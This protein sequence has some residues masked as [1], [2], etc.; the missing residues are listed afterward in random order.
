M[1]IEKTSDVILRYLKSEHDDLSMLAEDAVFTVMGSGQ[2]SRGPA[3]VQG[4]THY[5]YHIAFNAVFENR[6]LLFAE[7]NAVL[8]GYFVGKHIG[9]F[10]GIPATG[11]DVRVP[12]CIVYDVADN[13]I[14]QAR[15]YFE[16][17]VL[18]QQL[19]VSGG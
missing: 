2:E 18:M 16:L 19:G 15:I 12:I 8:E 3:A 9:E 13:K 6:V 1:S 17:P 4:M 7:N 10:A 14:Q 11:K 5:L